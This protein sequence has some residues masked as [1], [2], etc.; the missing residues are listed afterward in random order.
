MTVSERTTNRPLSQ[1]CYDN[2]CKVIPGG[3]NSPVRA[4]LDLNIPPLVVESALADIITDVDRNEYIDYCMSWGAVIHGHSHPEIV[5]VACDRL[6]KGSSFGATTAIEEKLAKKIVQLLPSCEKV[7]L[8]SSGTEATMTAT[9]VARGYTGKKLIIKFAGCYHGHAD[10]FLIQAGSG[11]T[12]LPESTSA[13]IP[14]ELV[15]STICLPYN[16]TKAFLD[17]L[18]NP[19]VQ[20]NL[21][22]VIIEPVAANMGLVAAEPKFLDAIR[23]RTKEIGALLI[24]DEVISGF[25]VGLHGAQGLYGITPDITCFGKV[26]GGGYPA[27]GFGGAAKIMD[28]LAPIGPVYQAGTLS[29][30]PIAM[31]AGL[32]AIEMLEAPGFYDALDKKTRIITDPIEEILHD[33]DIPACLNRVGSLFTLFVGVREVKNGEQS[34]AQDREQ[35]KKLFYYMFDNGVYMPPSPFEAWFVSAAHTEEHLE[36]TRDLLLDYLKAFVPDSLC[37]FA[38]L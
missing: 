2:L 15:Q 23:T 12:I 29:G 37:H 24:F 21:A 10:Y 27:A 17:L 1:K 28:Y 25:R 18:A 38:V 8:V 13:G 7:R 3:V 6:K 9:R 19:E 16:D 33:K 11:A 35:F 26:I 30:N 14:Q 22:C 20:E 36:K 5:R 32:K 34:K 31:E 4:F